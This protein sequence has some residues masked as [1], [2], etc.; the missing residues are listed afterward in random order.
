[1]PLALRRVAPLCALLL[2]ACGGGGGDSPP[3]T[4]PPQPSITFGVVPATFTRDRAASSILS[5]VFIDVH[6]ATSTT[7]RITGS[8]SK[9]G[10]T[11]V[12]L[13]TS[14]PTTIMLGIVLRPPATIY[15]GTYHD[16]LKLNV[17]L[18]QACTQPLAG[19]PMTIPITYTVA[20]T[21]PVTGATGPL[22]DTGAAPFVPASRAVLA[23][24]VIDAEYDRSLDRIVMVGSYPA[25][26]LY[27]YDGATGAEKSVALANVPTAVS[28]SPD[29]LKAAVGHVGKVSV[30]DLTTA[31]QPAAQ[32]PS[33]VTVSGTV[34][35]LV[36]DGQNRVHYLPFTLDSEYLHTVDL[37]TG[38]DHFENTVA[39]VQGPGYLR[40]HPSGSF[41]FLGD[42]NLSPGQ[43]A[44]WDI[45]GAAAHNV[46]RGSF[47]HLGGCG[48]LWISDA[49]DRVYSQC[50]YVLGTDGPLSTGLP[51]LGQMVLSGPPAAP[52]GNL[53]E[54]M[55]QWSPTH[56]IALVQDNASACD[57]PEFGV[58]C[59]SRVALFDSNTLQQLSVAALAPQDV[60]GTLH[61]Q[62]GQFV[63]YKAD[64]SRKYLLSY[65]DAMDSP[66]GAYYL[67]VMP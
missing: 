35:D 29:G 38:V 26:R 54:W 67:S 37:A 17:C 61:A 60:N 7:L 2:A 64:G 47:D 65:L 44:K 39:A 30:V 24:D 52:S 36:L 3:V 50:G 55:D 14:D 53:I 34:F 32:P 56:E 18:D 11:S 58:A 43:I 51:L 62:R 45:T 63:F 28:V 13:T 59:Y 10:V 25:N 6:N 4:T 21:D 1:M 42:A 40:L 8:Y 16:Q 22:P 23:H 48:N 31:G 41:V 66:Q 20:G 27:V 15:N 5:N 9:V 19:S 49:G 57:L 12:T 46:N 33:Q